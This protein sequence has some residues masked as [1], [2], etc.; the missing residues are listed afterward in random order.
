MSYQPRD[1]L[2]KD[3]PA[4]NSYGATNASSSGLEAGTA[5]TPPEETTGWFSS[6]TKKI[7]AGSALLLS[8]GMKV[9]ELI[10]TSERSRAIDLGSVEPV[11]CFE[12]HHRKL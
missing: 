1:P 9:A 7:I 8:G 5:N 4:P 3:E 12:C 6:S 11:T 10:I 2:L